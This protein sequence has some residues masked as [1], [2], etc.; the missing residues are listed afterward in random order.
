MSQLESALASGLSHDLAAIYGRVY[1]ANGWNRMSVWDGFNSVAVQAGIYEPTTYSTNVTSTAM[2]ANA[3]MDAGI[4]FMRYR[5]MDSRTQYPSNPS[6]AVEFSALVGASGTGAAYT[7]SNL[8]ASPDPKVDRII[9]EITDA[10]GDEFL[11]ASVLPNAA[12]AITYSANDDTLRG[13]PLLYDDFDHDVPPFFRHVEAFK[14]RLWGFG[15]Q[16][17]AEGAAEIP[18]VGVSVVGQNTEWGSAAVGRLLVMSGDVQREIASVVSNTLMLLDTAAASQAV[19]NYSIIDYSPDTLYFSKALFPESWPN[20]NQIRVLAGRP[21]KLRSANGYRN[22]LILFG[23]RSMERLVFGE[24]PF[25]DGAL[26]PVE[27]DRGAASRLC[28]VDAAGFLWALDYKGIHRY[29]GIQPEH[30]SEQIDPLF[31]PA[32]RSLGYVNFEYRTTFH[33]VHFPNRHQIVWFVVIQD[34]PGDTTTYTKPQHA[35]VYDY[36][37]DSFGLWKF[38]VPMVASTIGPGEDGETQTLIADENGRLW[39]MGIGST[40]GA[41]SDSDTELVI[42]S[43]VTAQNIL[44]SGAATLYA[45]NDGLAGTTVYSPDLDEVQLVDSNSASGLTLVSAFA[46]APSVGKTVYVGRIPAKWKSKA[47]SPETPGDLWDETRVCTLTFEPKASGTVRVRFYFN[48]SATAFDGYS[49]SYSDGGVTQDPDDN[50]YV[51]DITQ[52]HGTARIPVPSASDTT[53]RAIYAIEVEVEIISGID[54]EMDGIQI[55]GF[56]DEEDQEE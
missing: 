7:F 10:G 48:R 9:V 6:E 16:V 49:E 23:E 29:A 38:D 42:A 8:V 21:E 35:I 19:R 44:F 39:V 22:D 2:T 12:G 28:T 47:F 1:R 55:D 53:Q 56:T 45:S 5:Y 46:S 26:E 27:G 54:F 33:A 4:H 51:V 20:E 3:G 40:D 50:F 15:Q 17:Y 14:G 11:Q 18:S 36:R 43:G 37:N 32:D 31:D 41:H 25:I 52:E 30:V 34:L 13:V 24:N